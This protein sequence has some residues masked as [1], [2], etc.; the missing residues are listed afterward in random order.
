MTALNEPTRRRRWPRRALVVLLFAVLVGG[1]AYLFRGTLQNEWAV[2]QF[3]RAAAA[4]DPELPQYRD[5]LLARDENA[6]LAARLADDPDPKVRAAAVDALLAGQPSAAKRAGG[7]RPA[8]GDPVRSWRKSDHDAVE[9]LLRD[10]DETVR[11][12]ALLAVAGRDTAHA[13]G[14][15]LT[16]TL[17][18]GAAEERSAVAAHLAH[19]N[20]SVLIE[21][22]G[23]AN[24]PDAVRV[25]AMRGLDTY[26]AGAIVGRETVLKSALVSA[27]GSES[28]EV[29]R[30]AVTAL[31]Y[32]AD[33][34]HVWLDLLCNDRQKDQHPLVLRTWID[35]LSNEDAHGRHWAETHDAWHQN[36]ASALRCAVTGHVMCES[37]VTQ[38]RYLERSPPIAEA[39]AMTDRGGP[40]G[41]AFDVQLNRLGNVLSVLSA[42]R[43]HCTTFETPPTLTGRLPNEA[44]TGAPPA[45]SLHAYV[46]QQAKP[47]WEWCL[48]HEG[49]YV[50]RFLTAKSVVRNYGANP[51]ANPTTARPLSAVLVE[52]L[53]TRA[54]F[55]RLR[56][57]YEPK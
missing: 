15:Q 41:R 14:E 28:P 54:E 29:R 12:K 34:S 22:I 43:W 21:V 42:V 52:L 38:I 37:A 47:I 44:P 8:G 17:K 32:A 30:T 1:P 51:A 9:R 31:R 24:Q 53:L 36:S 3:R 45:R 50:T 5:R 6:D 46:F 49:A 33:S 2:W 39:A 56:T 18:T 20:G 7:D 25:A 35:A 4:D 26:G 16:E 57:Q 27:L 23:D 13:F 40:V 55:D 10:G 19:W 48:K 11:R